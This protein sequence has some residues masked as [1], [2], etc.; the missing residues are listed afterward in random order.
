MTNSTL[1]NKTPNKR[2]IKRHLLDLLIV[3]LIGDFINLLFNP[4]LESYLKFLPW[5]SL[6]SLIIGG[7][8]WKGNEVLGS[9][10]AKNI[11]SQKHPFRSLR[12]SLISMFIYSSLA[13][14]VVNYLWWV[15]VIGYPND[16]LLTFQ[17]ML[18]ML[19]E[20][21]I[22]II[23]TSILFSKTYFNA[24]RELAVNEE[25][26]KNES[27]AHQYKALQNQVN[28]HFLFNS[29][30]TLSSLVYK[31]QDQAVKF[32]KQLSEVYRY[33][34]EH[35]DAELV[36]ISIELTFVK[37]YV[38]LQKIRHG[39]SLNIS[40]DI[41]TNEQVQVVPMALQM[42]IENTI[43]H[44][45]VSEENPLFVEVSL[46]QDYVEVKNNLQPKSSIED[47]GGIGLHNLKS[48]YEPLS[49]S[50]IQVEENKSD[51]I[52]RVPVLKAKK[53]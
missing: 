22:T 1:K 37:N 29:L 35:K 48:R 11:D 51:F 43:K 44:N 41:N 9:L 24:W 6:Y 8:L 40:Y 16:F 50:P 14:I 49:D 46:N 5:N 47:S 31:D 17:G 28:P 25:R 19:I 12:W 10:I 42:L 36:D 32:I 4:N 27:L 3:V 53:A 26:I 13:I 52:V 30:N 34:L 33:V 15:H 2:S 38:F 21:V 39:N 20:Y 7:F 18:I 23:I 45:I